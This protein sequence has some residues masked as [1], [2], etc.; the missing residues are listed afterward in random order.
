MLDFAHHNEAQEAIQGSKKAGDRELREHRL[1]VA[2]HV[3]VVRQADV[4]LAQCF[5]HVCVGLAS[6][7]HYKLQETPKGQLAPSLSVSPTVSRRWPIFQ[8]A[9]RS[10]MQLRLGGAE[11]GV[12][13]RQIR[14]DLDR[15]S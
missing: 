7:L 2:K 6:S 3:A 1:H 11:L 15:A 8:G 10:T 9:R 13:P 12:Y 14:S 5:A 4:L